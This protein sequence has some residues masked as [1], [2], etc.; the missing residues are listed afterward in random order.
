MAESGRKNLVWDIRR[1]LL[2]LSAEELFQIAKGVVPVLEEGQP[3]LTEGDHESCFNHISSFMYSKH[4][5]ESED[6]GM[7]QLL[8]LK[9]TID[10]VVMNRN[11][12]LLSDNRGSD[13]S[14]TQQTVQEINTG[15]ITDQMLGHTDNPGPPS[16]T[17]PSRHSNVSTASPVRPKLT[18]E[19]AETTNA[20]LLEM[21][22]SYEELGKRLRQSIMTPT[23]QYPE[24]FTL[25]PAQ[26]SGARSDSS[27]KSSTSQSAAHQGREGMI[28]LREL[29]YLQRREFKVQG[30]QVG[31]H[32]SD[33]SYSNV[34]K[35]IEEGIKEG[36][37]DTEIVRSVLRI[38]KP[39][40][41]KDML[42]N[43][44]DLTVTE[45]KG[46]LQA[47]LR[48]KNSTELFQE[49]MCARQ[50]DN[51]T[52]QQ[53]LYRVIGLKQRVLFTSKL[54]DTGIKYNAATVQDV[55]LH[56]VYQGLGQ[57][58]ND[59][60]RELKPL[61]SNS[62]V[63]DETILRH[64][65][66]ITSEESERWAEPRTAVIPEKLAV[67]QDSRTPALKAPKPP[68]ERSVQTYR[69]PVRVH[70]GSTQE[71]PVV[72]APDSD[73]HLPDSAGVYEGGQTWMETQAVP[74]TV[75][76]LLAGEV[77]MEGDNIPAIVNSPQ[78]D[79]EPEI[80]QAATS[81][82]CSPIPLRRS[83]RQRQPGRVFT[84]SSLGHPTYQTRPT[85]N[86]LDTYIVPYWHSQPFPLSF[87]S[88][89]L[90]QCPYLPLNYPLYGY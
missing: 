68:K 59:I 7:V 12:L 24:G 57:K 49:L 1:S 28:S 11:V 23:A 42:I 14:R 39:G 36:F 2:T 79:T 27:Y 63:G 51:E 45:L 40:T 26:T 46:F 30:G 10:T 9:D 62:E 22:T 34:C 48:E 78:S 41:F 53:F 60:R 13:I 20:D 70:D 73:E 86:A 81:Q 72:E 35:Q 33:I 15:I 56:T 75:P 18:S 87:Q 25:L 5:L 65:M 88:T 47:H 64:V 4:L 52:P 16:S 89:P 29:S 37:P 8:I 61:L 66:R 3:E 17:L 43:K 90:L 76:T 74:G 44:D 38:I 82:P 55:F 85:V 50:D 19:V 67:S 21:L 31:D 32:S 71:T 84:Y 83:T 6:S 54:S 77:M 58:H 69:E 80:P